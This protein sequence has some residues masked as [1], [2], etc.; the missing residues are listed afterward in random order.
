MP[1]AMGVGGGSFDTLADRV[2]LMAYPTAAANYM[3]LED[4]LG[5]DYEVPATRT[6]V[7]TAVQITALAAVS[8]IFLFTGTTGVG[9]GVPAPA[10]AVQI[11]SRFFCLLANETITL[12]A[13]HAVA[14]GLFPC[15]QAIT[16][17]VFCNVYGFLV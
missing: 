9:N 1:F 7:I 10:G 12:P 3:T 4:Y 5:N 11:S 13:N 16:D 6:L 8:G 14:A 15:V 17:G 2:S